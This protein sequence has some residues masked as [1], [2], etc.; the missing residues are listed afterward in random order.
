MNPP[1]SDGFTRVVSRFPPPSLG[2]VL[3]VRAPIIRAPI[4]GERVCVLVPPIPVTFVRELHVREPLLIAAAS[5]VGISSRTFGTM[6]AYE[7]RRG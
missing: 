5:P 1:P 4:K 3:C 6:R 7:R 2:R